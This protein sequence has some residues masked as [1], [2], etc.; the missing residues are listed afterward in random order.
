MDLQQ[1]KVVLLGNASVGKSSILYRFITGEFQENIDPTV[2][3]SFMGKIIKFG[4]LSVKL[5]IW[6]TAGQERYNSFAKM[7]CR[8]AK[9]VVFVFD[10]TQYTSFEGIDKWYQ[11][12]KDVNID[13]NAKMYI[14]A[15]KADL[16][17]SFTNPPEVDEFAAKIKAE[18]FRVSAKKNTGIDE[19][20]SKVAENAVELSLTSLK[21]SA[22][23]LRSNST[24]K[25]KKSKC[26]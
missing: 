5:N 22:L 18:V 24:V 7:Y 15:N 13:T 3:A 10:L 2:G 9:A 17:P 25:K 11:M 19:L 16:N 21:Q 12:L 20:F 14:V 26:C 6:D 8:D 23:T 1:I 4:D